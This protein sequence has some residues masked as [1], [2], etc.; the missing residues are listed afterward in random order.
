MISHLHPPEQQIPR[1]PGPE[2]SETHTG[3]SPSTAIHR[4]KRGGRGGRQGAE[5]EARS[6]PSLPR[7]QFCSMVN[8]Q[9]SFTKSK[10]PHY[11][12]QLVTSSPIA[13][14]VFLS[15]HDSITSPTNRASPSSPGGLGSN[16]QLEQPLRKLSWS[17]ERGFGSGTT[18][19]ERALIAPI[20]QLCN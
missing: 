19:E 16:Q 2:S 4:C 14:L 3:T 18:G 10:R 20:P 5:G 1:R 7:G 13:F 15:F 12:H 6:S 17:V 9:W 8:H 11:V